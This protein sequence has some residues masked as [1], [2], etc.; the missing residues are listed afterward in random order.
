MVAHPPEERAATQTFESA[1]APEQTT[2]YGGNYQS[3]GSM[4]QG[5][6]GG[7]DLKDTTRR[8]GGSE[9]PMMQA[10]DANELMPPGFGAIRD[11]RYAFPK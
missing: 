11:D 2:D 4:P 7:T 3:Q 5:T 1:A 8:E 6:V 10:I 9:S